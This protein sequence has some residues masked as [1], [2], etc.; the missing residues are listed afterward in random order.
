MFDLA[1]GKQVQELVPGWDT[2]GQ[3]PFSSALWLP[4]G[5]YLVAYYSTNEELHLWDIGA[6][7]IVRSHVNGIL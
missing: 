3:V 2:A 6:G 1:T 4:G 5:K 7:K